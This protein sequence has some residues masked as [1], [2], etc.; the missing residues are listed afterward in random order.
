M[1]DRND[2]LVGLQLLRAVAALMV[3]FHH[4]R[5]SVRGAEVLTTV[6]EAGVDI[7]FVISGFVMAYT[8]R[9]LMDAPLTLGQRI[10]ASRD[11]LVNRVLRVVPLYWLATAWA[12]HKGLGTRLAVGNVLKDMLFIPHLSTPWAIYPALVQGWTLN[13]EMLFYALFAASL[14]AG[15]YARQILIAGIATLA[16]IGVVWVVHWGVPAIEEAG[17]WPGSARDTF[18][19]VPWFYT[20]NIMLEFCFGI[21]LESMSRRQAFTHPE[22]WRHCLLAL[23]GFAA[24][25]AMHPRWPRGLLQGAP[26]ALIVWS[27]IPACR[28]LRLRVP[29]LLGNASYCI[30]LFHWTSFAM[31]KPLLP[32]QSASGASWPWIAALLLAHLLSAILVGIAIHFYVEQPMTRWLKAQFGRHPSRD[33]LA[34]ASP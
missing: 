9:H 12:A 29:V 20:N 27:S 11:F 31:L 15:R 19:V 14:L 26:A 33:P 32:H 7:F 1:A 6:G 25:C 3:V 17:R 10:Q 28:G 18:L 8:T 24:L 13:Y 22:R 21:V 5:G 2:R 30:Y 4:A 34:A 23:A 16:A